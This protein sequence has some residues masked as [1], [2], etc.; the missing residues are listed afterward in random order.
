M[1]QTGWRIARGVTELMSRAARQHEEAVLLPFEGLLCRGIVIPHGCEAASLH[2][3]H[4]LIHHELDRRQRLP[5]RNL[6]HPC[7]GTPFL[8]R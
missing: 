8:S 5:R 1:Q 6:G 3:V 2:H 4:D 7:L